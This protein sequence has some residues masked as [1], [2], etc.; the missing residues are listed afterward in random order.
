ME[1][2]IVSGK[3]SNDGVGGPLLGM[4]IAIVALMILVFA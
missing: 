4:A 3:S 2:T 1:G